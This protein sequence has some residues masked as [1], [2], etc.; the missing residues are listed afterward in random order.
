MATE[1]AGQTTL[2]QENVERMITG[3]ALAKYTAKQAVMLSGSA[4]WLESYYQE[5]KTVPTAGTTSAIKGIGRMSPFPKANITWT[6]QTAYMEKYGLEDVISYEDAKT[7]AMDVIARTLIR[8]AEGVV[9]AV[10]DEIL[11]TLS[12]N[13]TAGTINT[14]AI[15]AGYEWDSATIANRNPIQDILNAKA[16]IKIDNYFDGNILLFLNPQD[17]ANVLGNSNVRNAGQFFTD[18]VTRNGIIGK[19]IGCTLIETNSVPADSALMCIS[20]K[21][22]T[23]K[24]V[25][26]LTVIS[27]YDAG[28]KYTIR[29]FEMGTTQLTNPEAVCLISNTRA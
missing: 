11:V 26:P 14:V 24:E 19:L 29:A 9:K 7:D 10:D 16:T 8:V 3:L 28:I 4:A 1:S 13:W 23:W 18:A 22:G 6:K 25:T 5:T 21:C 15:S 17:V 27:I 2:R 20:K 12:E